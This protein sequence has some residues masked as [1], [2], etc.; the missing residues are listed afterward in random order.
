MRRFYSFAFDSVRPK[1]SLVSMIIDCE[2]FS[3]LLSDRQVVE[4]A[5]FLTRMGFIL[6]RLLLLAPPEICIDKLFLPP[7]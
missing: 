4:I 6:S 2:Y 7:S 3:S 5:H 1:H